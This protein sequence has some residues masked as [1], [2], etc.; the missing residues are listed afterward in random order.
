MDCLNNYIWSYLV[1]SSEFD[2][3]Q[4]DQTVPKK[5]WVAPV[6][7]VLAEELD[8]HGGGGGGRETSGLWES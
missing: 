4:T 7:Q 5:T 6:L 8:I 2:I 3:N 1:H